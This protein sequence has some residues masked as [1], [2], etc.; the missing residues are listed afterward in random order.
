MLGGKI[1]D[2]RK[3][4]LTTTAPMKASLT[5]GCSGLAKPINNATANQTKLSTNHARRVLN[6]LAAER[7]VN[8]YS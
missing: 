4:K 3:N 2:S 8:S 7:T 1:L 5:K 6:G